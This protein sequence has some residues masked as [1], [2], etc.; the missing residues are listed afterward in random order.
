MQEFCRNDSVLHIN[1]KKL[2]EFFQHCETFTKTWRNGCFVSDNQ[3]SLLF[4]AK[5]WVGVRKKHSKFQMLH[6]APSKPPGQLGAF[7]TIL[8]RPNIQVGNGRTGG[9]T[10][11]APDFSLAKTTFPKF[12]T[13]INI[14]V[15][16][17]RQQKNCPF[18]WTGGPCG[19]PQQ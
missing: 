1:V 11:Y 15:S 7:K 3:V 17:H 9:V 14:F 13:F 10:I 4:P 12:H 6:E 16:L 19:R 2:G 5:R 8:G 18:L